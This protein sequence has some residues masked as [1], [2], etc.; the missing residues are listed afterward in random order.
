MATPN[1]HGISLLKQARAIPEND[2]MVKI[3]TNPTLVVCLIFTQQAPFTS[4]EDAPNRIMKNRNRAMNDCYPKSSARS[5]AAAYTRV[6]PLLLKIPTKNSAKK[7]LL[8]FS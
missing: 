7:Y 8:L 6:Y 1:I 2:N 4:L 3:V 5:E